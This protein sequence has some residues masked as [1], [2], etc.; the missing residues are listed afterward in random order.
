[1]K[2][3]II[4]LFAILAP[5][6]SFGGV[7]GGGGYVINC[8]DSNGSEYTELL[9]LYEGVENLGLELLPSTS[10][11]RMDYINSVKNGYRL[12]GY[13][14]PVS[15]GEILDNLE[16][17]MKRVE[18]IESPHSLPPANDLGRIMVEIPSS[19]HLEQVA[20]FYDVSN[21]LA[22]K[23]DVWERLS[24]LSKAALMEHEIFYRHFRQFELAPAGFSEEVRLNIAI[25]FSVNT[26][27]V[28]SGLP[29][30]AK[31][32]FVYFR[33]SK[34]FQEATQY[35]IFKVDS[36][37]TRVQFKQLAGRALMSL[38]FMDLPS[39]LSVDQIIPIYS[40]SLLGWYGKVLDFNTTTDSVTVGMYY[41]NKLVKS[42]SVSYL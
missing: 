11:F 16:S 42:I 1:M 7:D 14:P 2:N 24:S 3:L 17:F 15:S 39:E 32:D 19:C 12:Q 23:K 33:N 31:D 6:L 26:L 10:D 18:W 22:V 37:T 35:S 5:S 20:Y 28:F 38:S 25:R 36:E 9:D 8:I 21:K 4:G 29:R 27:P 30:N 41:Y 40:N 13:Q 34:G